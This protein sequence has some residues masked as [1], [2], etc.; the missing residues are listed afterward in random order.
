METPNLV[1]FVTEL[2]EKY[3]NVEIYVDLQGSKI[4]ISRNQPQMTLKK[5]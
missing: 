4:R 3:K 1:Q 5:D 2:T